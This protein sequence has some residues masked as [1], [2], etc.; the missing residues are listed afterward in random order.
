MKSSTASILGHRAEQSRSE[1]TQR[2][3]SLV[4]ALS[5]L[6]TKEI[7][8]HYFKHVHTIYLGQLASTIEC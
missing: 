8:K 3:S 2:D 1:E 6:N 4:S 5:N 7:L